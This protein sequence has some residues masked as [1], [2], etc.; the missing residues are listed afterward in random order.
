MLLPPIGPTP[1]V[2][3]THQVGTRR[4]LVETVTTYMTGP[5][6]V[7]RPTTGEAVTHVPCGACGGVGVYRVFDARHA[8]ALRNRWR[9]LTAVLGSVTV[10]LA[11]Y[12]ITT[13]PERFGSTGI[14]LFVGMGISGAMASTFWYFLRQED[15]VRIDSDATRAANHT[16]FDLFAH[17]LKFVKGGAAR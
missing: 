5:I 3:Q 2:R 13:A 16:A 4:D 17:D 12:A 11:M 9:A 1:S 15:G 6:D 10:G 14:A 8:L 7:T